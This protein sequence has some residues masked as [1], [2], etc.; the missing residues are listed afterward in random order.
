MNLGSVLDAARGQL[1]CI[2]YGSQ[3]DC[4]CGPERLYL[5]FHLFFC[6]VIVLLMVEILY[7]QVFDKNRKMSD[8]QSNQDVPNG[9]PPPGMLK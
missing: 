3:V 2:W 5:F 8:N 7:Y 4:N 1:R 9:V 6:Y